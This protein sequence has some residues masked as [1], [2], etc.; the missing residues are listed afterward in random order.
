MLNYM[1]IIEKGMSVK[2]NEA[3][4]QRFE[5]VVFLI[6]RTNTRRGSFHE[7]ETARCNV[8]FYRVRPSF[9]HLHVRVPVSMS[10][11][12]F[13][14]TYKHKHKHSHVYTKTEL[15][16]RHNAKFDEIA[17]F[18]TLQ[19]H[20]IR[21]INN[22]IS[23]SFRSFNRLTRNSQNVTI[24]SHF[25]SCV[26]VSLFILSMYTLLYSFLRLPPSPCRP[27][28]PRPSSPQPPYP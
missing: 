17:T 3:R 22:R 6:G 15:G 20:L 12:S 16:N 28:R 7:F 4:S 13:S 2:E 21:R 10:V 11:S 26:C 9:Y 19:D 1:Y 23:F 14:C 18:R 25:F 8:I 24:L 27:G 5:H